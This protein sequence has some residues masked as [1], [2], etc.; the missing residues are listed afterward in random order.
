MI[1]YLYEVLL[2]YLYLGISSMP[3]GSHGI[4]FPL[5][6]VFALEFSSSVLVVMFCTRLLAE[7][8]KRHVHLK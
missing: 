2:F 8:E 6:S 5:G 1:K 3:A 4:L 7:S